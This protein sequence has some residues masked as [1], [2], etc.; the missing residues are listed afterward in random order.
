MKVD[1]DD[2]FGKLINVF[3]EFISSQYTKWLISLQGLDQAEMQSKLEKVLM[4]RPT[5][6][7]GG[8]QYLLESTPQ[9][10]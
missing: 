2:T 7:S 5:A 9:R 10:P 6:H 4:A 1:V 3:Q 8:D